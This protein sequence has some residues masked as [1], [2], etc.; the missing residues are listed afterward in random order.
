MKKQ[1]LT[2]WDNPHQ[3]EKEL[4]KRRKIKF[5]K[6]RSFNKQREDKYER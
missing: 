1:F 2:Y 3:W 4:K 5:Y 6:K